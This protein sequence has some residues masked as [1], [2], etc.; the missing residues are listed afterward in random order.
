[1]EAED[2]LTKDLNREWVDLFTQKIRVLAL[3]M[4]ELWLFSIF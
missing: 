2:K 4:N 3:K 1:M